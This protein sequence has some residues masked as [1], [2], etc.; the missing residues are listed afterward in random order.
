MSLKTAF[1]AKD[2]YSLDFIRI[3]AIAGGLI[4]LGLEVYTVVWQHTPF[5]WQDFGIGLGS[6]LTGA[7][8]GLFAKK[9]T[10]PDVNSTTS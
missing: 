8:V 5:S 3:L 1:T 2:N 10:E 6:L 7:G 4:G 9:D